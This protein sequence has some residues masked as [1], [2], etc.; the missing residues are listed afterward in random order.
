M[1]LDHKILEEQKE[2]TVKRESKKRELLD[3][4]ASLE[5]HRNAH[6]AFSVP[7]FPYPKLS[8][9]LDTPDDPLG[10]IPKHDKI[11]CV[12]VCTEEALASMSEEII[13]H[14]KAIGIDTEY[15]ELEKVITIIIAIIFFKN[16]LLTY[17][18]CGK[19]KRDRTQR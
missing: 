8:L 1:Q 7:Q 13:K 5:K 10:A 12:W 9:K 3:I 11:K 2:W 4:N 6:D 16:M 18:H 19:I 14:H 15:H 17:I